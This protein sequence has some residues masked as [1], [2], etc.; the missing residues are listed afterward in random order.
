MHIVRSKRRELAL[1]SLTVAGALILGFVTAR[2]IVGDVPTGDASITT[3][4]ADSVSPVATETTSETSTS[5]SA[6]AMPLAAIP[7][8]LTTVT[9]TPVVTEMASPTSTKEVFVQETFD[10]PTPNFPSRETPRWTVSYVDQRYQF[11]LN[12]Q[13]LIGASLSLPVENYRIGVDIAVVEGGAGIVFLFSQPASRYHILFSPDGA[14]TV[15]R[16]DDS[17]AT[18]IVDWTPSPALQNTPGATNRLEIERRGGIIR[19]FANGQ[20]L[21]DL[22]VPAGQFEPQFGLVLTSRKGQGEAT[23]DNLLGER[24]PD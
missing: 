10:S 21:T 5:S 7:S 13:T 12:G 9:P 4:G 18:T 23:F 20:L 3:F 19:F 16:R 8:P 24:L 6:T 11:K 15:E 14:Y 2:L 17:A 1:V 22:A